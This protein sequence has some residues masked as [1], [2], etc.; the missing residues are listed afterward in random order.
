MLKHVETLSPAPR[1]IALRVIGSLPTD[2]RNS[3]IA[4]AL[5][6]A[7]TLFGPVV[8]TLRTF[9]R[10]RPAPAPGTRT[11]ARRAAGRQTAAHVGGPRLRTPSRWR[12][13]RRA[14]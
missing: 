1:A 8:A 12:A 13:Q 5:C 11:A 9:P 10:R 7:G 2:R 6:T 4:S 3:R 14:P